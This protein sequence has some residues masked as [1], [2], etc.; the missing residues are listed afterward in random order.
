PR[1]TDGEVDAFYRL[2]VA[3]V[4]RLV[5]DTDEFKLN[6]NLVIIDFL[7]RHGMISQDDPD[8]IPILRGLRSPLP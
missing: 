1:C 6:C 4:A 3:E 8:Y 2:P 5:S 7:V